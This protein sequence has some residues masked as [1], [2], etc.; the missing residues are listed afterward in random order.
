MS[1]NLKDCEHI[2]HARQELDR[3]ASDLIV[4]GETIMPEKVDLLFDIALAK[5]EAAKIGIFQDW[6]ER[7]QSIEGLAGVSGELSSYY[8]AIA[9]LPALDRLENELIGKE[10]KRREAWEKIK[11]HVAGPQGE[12]PAVS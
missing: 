5:F 6:L 4:Q 10:D 1:I 7:C 9:A 2:A 11:P 3:V 12:M 8:E